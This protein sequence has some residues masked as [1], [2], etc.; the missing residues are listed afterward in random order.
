MLEEFRLF[1]D[2]SDEELELIQSRA[3]ARNFPKNAVI[4]NEGDET[5]SLYLIQSGRVKFFLSDADGK[6]VILNTEGPG[7][8]F[9]ELSLLDGQPRSVSVMTLEPSTL[10]VVSRNDLF[11]CLRRNPAI[12]LKLLRHLS[13]RL[14]EL[15]DDVRSLAL[16]DVYGRVVRLLEQL[17]T[18][19][20]GA[21][22]VSEK[23]TH[24]EISQRV[25]SSREMVSRI[26]GDLGKGGYLD[27]SGERILILKALPRHW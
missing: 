21:R 5:A 1:S 2:L 25:G 22:V 18:E 17:A 20:D 10:Q 7:G 6:E 12:S 13:R 26:M 3:V 16:V 4:L 27:T 8:Y 11:D 24:Q 14:R 23:L 15:S 9:G 19:E